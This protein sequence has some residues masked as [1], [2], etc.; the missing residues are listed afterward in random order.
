MD[1]DEPLLLSKGRKTIGPK[2]SANTRDLDFVIGMSLFAFF[3]LWKSGIP[4]FREA[5]GYIAMACWIAG[6]CYVRILGLG[7]AVRFIS[8][9]AERFVNPPRPDPDDNSESN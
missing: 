5:A 4:W 9:I 1:D 3:G 8:R 7:Y 6:I 2:L